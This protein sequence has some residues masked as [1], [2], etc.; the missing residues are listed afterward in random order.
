MLSG[1]NLSPNQLSALIALALSVPIALGIYFING[2]WEVAGIAFG[3]IKS[4]L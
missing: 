2:K 4:I 3:I 1:K